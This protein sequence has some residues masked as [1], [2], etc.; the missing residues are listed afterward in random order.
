MSTIL[1]RAQ[2]ARAIKAAGATSPSTSQARESARAALIALIRRRCRATACRTGARLHRGGDGS[3]GHTVHDAGYYNPGSAYAHAYSATA[4]QATPLPPALAH[5]GL[6]ADSIFPI[7]SIGGGGGGRK[8]CGLA[9]SQK[10][11]DAVLDDKARRCL[12]Q[13][14]PEQR[15]DL[16]AGVCTGIMHALRA[17]LSGGR[18]A[19]AQNI[20]SVA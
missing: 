7:S 11:V 4:P 8:H 5:A 3:H 19:N 14:T 16:I 13:A 15:R 12:A 9:L 20:R 10:A 17:T 2:F 18:V 6:T 1:T